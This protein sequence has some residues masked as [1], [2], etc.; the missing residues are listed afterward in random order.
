MLESYLFIITPKK[1][2]LIF[3]SYYKYTKGIKINSS[4]TKNTCKVS[5]NENDFKC[6]GQSYTLQ[7]IRKFSKLEQS[8]RTNV[9]NPNHQDAF[10]K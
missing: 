5:F 1:I 3:Q 2:L 8:S 10:G 4:H 6:S 9:S 7:V